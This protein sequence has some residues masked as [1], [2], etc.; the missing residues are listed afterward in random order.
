MDN[1][2]QRRGAFMSDEEIEQ[3]LWELSE[4]EFESSDT[5]ERDAPPAH[6]G[7]RD[8]SH[9]SIKVPIP[10]L[11]RREDPS[12]FTSGDIRGPAYSKSTLP[13]AMDIFNKHASALDIADNM[14]VFK[15]K[16]KAILYI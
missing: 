2:D 5:E 7:P 10:G 14:E 4:D 13:I 8:P 6:T 3:Y 12:I 16:T 15:E 1:F 11:R 9:I